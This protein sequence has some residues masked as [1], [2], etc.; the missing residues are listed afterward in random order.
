MV[1]CFLAELI[2]VGFALIEW[3]LRNPMLQK[4]SA[5]AVACLL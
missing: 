4:R 5:V 1:V 2:L 3:V